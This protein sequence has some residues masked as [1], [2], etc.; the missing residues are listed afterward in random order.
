[1][2]VLCVDIGTGTQ[3][4]FLYDSNID[5]ENGFKLVVPAP[6][7]II[8]RQLQQATKEG[9]PVLLT[10]VTMGGGPSH[11]AAEDHLAAGLDIYATPSAARSFNDD[12]QTIA[13]MGI[14]IIDPRDI[15]SLSSNAQR[16]EMRDFDFEAI[17]KALSAFGVSLSNLSAVAVA[18]FD[19]GAAPSDYSDRRFRFDYIRER[20]GESNKLSTFAFRAEDVPK[21]MT[22]LRSV[23]E[24]AAGVDAPLILMDTAPAAV[25]G[26]CQDPEVL[27]HDRKIVA[28]V[29]N[30]HTLAFHLDSD[31]IAGVFEHHTGLLDSNKMDRLLLELSE[32]TISN[33]AVFED[34]GHGAFIQRDFQ[35]LP[36]D[37]RIQVS[38]TGPRRNLMAESSLKPYFA[39]PFGDMMLAGCF[40]L[41]ASTAEL[42][43][44][45]N[46]GIMS[47][48][49]GY[50]G[51]G[52][53][54]WEL[55]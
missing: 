20:I 3:D 12:L 38:V 55:S 6:T 37:A 8:R 43:P 10:G 24:S 22:R 28:N 26:A 45:L 9:R 19:H 16:I 42:L 51:S 48:M 50:G 41:L 7:M 54:P 30:F 1:M 21:R 15:E 53:P 32:G 5:I 52:T 2:R 11:W 47:N 25:L 27:R 4:I 14:E 29:G 17:S 18:V 40:G 39:T 23:V 46:E 31:K 34:S 44:N 13:D 33:Q 49:K 35:K 36:K